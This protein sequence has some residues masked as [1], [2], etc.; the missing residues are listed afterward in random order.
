MKLE[1]KEIKAHQDTP[2]VWEAHLIKDK[3]IAGLTV[4]ITEGL[5]LRHN[6]AKI[7]RVDEINSIQGPVVHKDPR[8]GKC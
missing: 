1:L 5:E 6:N 8:T 2:K 7:V 4:D 3:R